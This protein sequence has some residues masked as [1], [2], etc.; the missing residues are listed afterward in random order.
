MCSHT[1]PDEEQVQI[2]WHDARIEH[3]EDTIKW[4]GEFA[5]RGRLGLR[6]RQEDGEE[7]AQT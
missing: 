2:E 4:A 5:L 1:K 6:N 3:A 7:C